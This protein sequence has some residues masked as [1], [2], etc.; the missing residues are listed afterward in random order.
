MLRRIAIVT[1]DEKYFGKMSKADKDPESQFVQ[2]LPGSP[3]PPASVGLIAPTAKQEPKD[4]LEAAIGLAKRYDELLYLIADVVD[5]QE[6]V[7]PGTSKRVQEHASRFAAALKLPPEE[8]L[9]LTRAALLRGIGMLKVPVDVRFKKE[10]LTYDEWALLQ[11]HPRFGA[12]MV[13]ATDALKDTANAILTH[14][15][16][17]DGTGYPQGMEA[18]HIPRLG[19]IMKILDVYCAMTSARHYREGHATHKQA[20]EHLKSERGKH[21]DPELV[22]VFIKKEVGQTPAG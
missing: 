5:S 15:E 12:D 9:T 21:F 13:A 20:I 14:H 17:Y 3:L 1:A 8:H 18:E 10:M 4:V 16:C 7:A 2:V 6:G 19:R 11:A 22:D